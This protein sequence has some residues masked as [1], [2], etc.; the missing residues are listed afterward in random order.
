LALS[1]PVHRVPADEVAQ[2]ATPAAAVQAESLRNSR[3]SM[4]VFMRQLYHI[5]PSPH[6]LNTTLAPI[7]SGQLIS[8]F[9]T[10]EDFLA[11]TRDHEPGGMANRLPAIGAVDSRPALRLSPR[12]P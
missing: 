9:K 6:N 3:L 1:V 5:P 12:P 10:N 4:F 2:P 7:F 8:D 11:L